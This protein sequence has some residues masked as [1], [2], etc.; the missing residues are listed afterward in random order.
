MSLMQTVELASGEIPRELRDESELTKGSREVYEAR[1]LWPTPQA[2]DA[3]GPKTPEQIA[4]MQE[5]TQAGVSN[6][7]ERAAMWPTPTV[8]SQQRE[9]CPSERF[10]HTPSLPSAAPIFME[11]A[12]GSAWPTPRASDYKSGE[13][14]DEIFGKNSRP[15]TEIAARFQTSP[16]APESE[17]PGLPSS[18]DDQTS[19]LLWPSPSAGIFNDGENLE[20]WEARRQVN[21]ANHGN[22]GMGTPLTIAVRKVEGQEKKR[23]NP[24]FV[25]WMMGLIPGWNDARRP[26]ERAEMASYLSRQR[27]R[28]SALLNARGYVFTIPPPPPAASRKLVVPTILRKS[29]PEKTYGPFS[30][31]YL[32][33]PWHY[34]TSLPGFG[35]TAAE[36]EWKRPGSIVPYKTMSVEQVA[37]LPIGEL[38]AKVA[39]LYMWTTNF[40]LPKVFELQMLKGWRFKYSTLIPWVKKPRGRPGFPAYPI[41]T[42]YLI[43][44]TRG[45]FP[46]WR[47]DKRIAKN[48]YDFPRGA[49]SQKPE[50]FYPLIEIV[51]PGPR[52]ELF[53]R[54]EGNRPGWATW[55]NECPVDPQ[56]DT[57]MQ[58]TIRSEEFMARAP[59]IQ[60]ALLRAKHGGASHQ[61]EVAE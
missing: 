46:G 34:P 18:P 3:Q 1:G 5:R 32:D 28:L 59:R 61:E 31:I 52:L 50:E 9:D 38:A 22:N 26:C 20:Q 17:T 40:H 2:H 11:D 41:F 13:V 43:Y 21:K 49:H 4:A 58:R 30:T 54:T 6:L 44:A 29:R 37:L 55:G 48:W 14:S 47:A 42:E 36:G 53:A 45:S 25:D 57:I 56:A 60:P 7:N 15:L 12:P 27:S 35:K 23:L 8:P 51:S 33:A 39:H 24:R 10:R 16:Q 19:P